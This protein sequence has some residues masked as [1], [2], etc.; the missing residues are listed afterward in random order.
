MFAIDRGI[1]LVVGGKA[2]GKAANDDYTANR[3]HQPS[4]EYSESWDW[5]GISQDVELFF[6]LGRE[7]A[8][9]STWP[10]WR[11][12]DEFRAV[13]DKSCAGEGGC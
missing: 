1:D 7:L 11:A 3:Y 4:D 2:A 13:R 5:S 6:S 10:N 12:G 9:G 8:D